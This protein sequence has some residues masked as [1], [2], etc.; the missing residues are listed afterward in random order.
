MRNAE[1]PLLSLA[2]ASSLRLTRTANLEYCCRHRIQGF[3]I[4][5]QTTGSKAELHDGVL[6]ATESERV[7]VQGRERVVCL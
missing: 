3:G 2:S 7:I 1:S 6:H 4:V 5:G